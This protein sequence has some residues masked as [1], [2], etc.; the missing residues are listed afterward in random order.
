M[1]VDAG[2]MLVGARSFVAR[3]RIDRDAVDAADALLDLLRSAWFEILPSEEV[4]MQSRRLLRV[5][6]LRAADALRLGAALVWSG[7]WAEG[8]FVSFD[9]RLREAARLEGFTIV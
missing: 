2:R 6:Q 1:V 9:E 3:R 5:H 7:A 4:R 8:E